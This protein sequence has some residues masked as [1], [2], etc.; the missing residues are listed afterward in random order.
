MF[1]D[2]PVDGLTNYPRQGNITFLGD[3]CQGGVVPVIE[4]HRQSGGL[5]SALGHFGS[6]ESAQGVQRFGPNINKVM[7]FSSHTSG[8]SGF[9]WIGS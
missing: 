5:V 8:V 2:E 7:Q 1:L 4:A 9:H 6:M 3:G